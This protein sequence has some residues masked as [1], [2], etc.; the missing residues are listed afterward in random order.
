MNTRLNDCEPIGALDTLFHRR[1]FL[2]DSTK[3]RHA[4]AALTLFPL[5]NRSF[6]ET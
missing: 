5:F 6:V 4:E 1:C 2:R 3:E